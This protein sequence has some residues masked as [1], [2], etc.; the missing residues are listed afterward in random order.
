[1]RQYDVQD[2]SV[3]QVAAN[4]NGVSYTQI[5]MGNGTSVSSS[6]TKN[7]STTSSTD[8]TGGR[9]GSIT[10][11]NNNTGG[12]SETVGLNKIVIPLL[13]AAVGMVAFA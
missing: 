6:G 12:A 1:M 10:S 3:F 9:S 13:L 7:G 11:T 8:N 5:A 4:L 2:G